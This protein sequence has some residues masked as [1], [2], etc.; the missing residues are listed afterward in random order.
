MI[1]L[2]SPYSGSTGRYLVEGGEYTQSLGS[3]QGRSSMS[4][5][6]KQA[7]LLRSLMPEGISPAKQAI[8]ER[9]VALWVADS[10]VDVA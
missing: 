4:P 8:I 10:K 2:N 9:L 1:Q 6:Q 7:E 3:N 5:N